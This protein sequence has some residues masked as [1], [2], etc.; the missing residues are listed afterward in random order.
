[1]HPMDLAREPPPLTSARVSVP[2]VSRTCAS[3]PT[4]PRATTSAITTAVSSTSL[5]RRIPIPTI[6][7]PSASGE[8]PAESGDGDWCSKPATPFGYNNDEEHNHE[9]SCSQHRRRIHADR[10][11]DRNRGDVDRNARPRRL[12]RDCHS[13]DAI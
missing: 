4:A 1:M 2:A 9:K 11:D 13:S 6:R 5:E 10:G 3:C 7:V 12:F 8:L